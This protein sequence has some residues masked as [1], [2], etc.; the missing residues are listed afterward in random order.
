MF[1]KASIR[2][3]LIAVIGLFHGF[4]TFS[5]NILV[6][7]TIFWNDVISVKNNEN[8]QENILSF[9]NSFQILNL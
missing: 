9:K 4:Y 8:K 1:T 7:D 3:L 5:Q 6:N 2:F